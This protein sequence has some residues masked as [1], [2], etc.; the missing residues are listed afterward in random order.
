MQL[1]DSSGIKPEEIKL[2]KS[3]LNKTMKVIEEQISS[4]GQNLYDQEEKITEFKKYIWDHSA[5]MDSSEMK[6]VM[7]I[8][9][10]DVYLSRQ[11]GSY[12]MKLYKIQNNP[13]FGSIIFED[14]KGVKEL[15]YIGIT[16]LVEDDYQHLIYDWRSPICS[17]FYDFETGTCAY[18]AP[19]GIIKGELKKKTSIS[20]C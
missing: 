1:N 20:N 2:E 7:A 17:L 11:S 14:C 3:R 5:S 9:E 8:H 12:F 6:Q 16:H 19:E 4:L 15:V 13:Y 18:D 10:T